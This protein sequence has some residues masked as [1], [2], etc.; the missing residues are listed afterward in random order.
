MELGTYT[1]ALGDRTL[2]EACAFLA[3]RGVTRVEL[4]CGGYPGRA[5][6]DPEQLLD[7]APAQRALLDLIHGHGMEI[8][9]LSCHGNAVHP[10]PAEARRF[11]RDFT[12]AILL[13]RQLGVEVVNSFSG[14]PGGAPG[15][16]TPNWTVCYWPE[17]FSRTLRYQWEDVLIPYWKEKAAFARDQ[18]RKIA[19]EMHPGFCVYNTSTL[20]RLREAAG[21]EIGANFDPSH[22]IWQGMDPCVSIRALGRAGAIFHVHA[23]DTR[24][25]PENC[26]RNGVL[27]GTHYSREL[28]RSWNFRT[29][30]YGHG[31]EYWRAILLE[32]RRSGYDGAVSIEHE[33]PLMSRREGLE[34]AIACLLPLILRDAPGN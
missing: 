8:S 31:E 23:K 2:A 15:D 30:G 6:C 4:A 12:R 25:D 22:L 28:E 21:P 19:L 34:K 5:H 18:G 32:L 17:D 10:D 33:D 1:T 27:D 3:E 26:A 29:V 14:C 24:I 11:D 16:R 7:N 9:A 20:L 13:A